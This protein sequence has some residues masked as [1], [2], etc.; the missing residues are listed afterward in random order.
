MFIENNARLADCAALLGDLGLQ[1]ADEGL[2]LNC[3]FL[4]QLDT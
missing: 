3:L 1:E 4:R 2:S